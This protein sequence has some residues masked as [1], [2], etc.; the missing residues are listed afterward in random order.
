MPRAFEILIRPLLTEKS[1]FL[2][3]TVHQYVFEVNPQAN[4][5]EIKKE[6]ER[7]FPKVKVV[8]VR[9]ATVRGKVR[10][11]GRSVGKRSNWKKAI[12]TLREGDQIEFFEGA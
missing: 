8:D 11:V 9:T 3:E 7:V 5:I 1:N 12:I 2:Q 4:R 10:R 6:I